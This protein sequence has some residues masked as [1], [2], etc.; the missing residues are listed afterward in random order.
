MKSVG[1]TIKKYRRLRKMSQEQL[2]EKT[3]VH[4]AT[5][6]RYETDR[7]SPRI[8]EVGRICEALEVEPWKFVHDASKG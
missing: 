8:D 3:G 1:K 2:A 6:C 7:Y 4:K 5:I